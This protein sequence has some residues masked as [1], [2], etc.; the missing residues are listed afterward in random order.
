M[1][2]TSASADNLKA[3]DSGFLIQSRWN[4]SMAVLVI[5]RARAT[6]GQRTGGGPFNSTALDLV[7]EEQRL[8][9]RCSG[10]DCNTDS[11]AIISNIDSSLAG[12][13]RRSNQITGV[14]ASVARVRMVRKFGRSCDGSHAR[15]GPHAASV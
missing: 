15:L 2:G 5:C 4:L 9:T 3:R 1:R 11:D 14:D 13:N 12:T 6:T 10:I 7:K 8:S